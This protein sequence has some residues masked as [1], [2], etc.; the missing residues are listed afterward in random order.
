MTLNYTR[1]SIMDTILSVINLD[2]LFAAPKEPEPTYK[3][4]IRVKFKDTGVTET[5]VFQSLSVFNF[6][7]DAVELQRWEH[8]REDG[9]IMNEGESLATLEKYLK[10]FEKSQKK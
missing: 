8:I 10:D 4:S 3:L 6:I 2:E 1:A 5:V 9:E 7:A